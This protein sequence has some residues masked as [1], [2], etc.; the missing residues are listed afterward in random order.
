MDAGAGEVGARPGWKL[1][2]HDEFDAAAGSLPDAT[3]WVF[4]VGGSGWGNNQ[5]EFDTARPENAAHDGQGELV[6]TARKESY[7]GK[8]YTSARLKTQGK[9]ESTYGR[10]E[11]RMKIPFGQGIWPAFWMLGADIAANAWPNCGEIDIMENVGKEPALVYGTLHGP[12]YS[13][14]NGV[15]ASYMVK[16]AAR[17]AD[18]YH[19]FAIEWEKDVVR[20]YVD[21]QLYQTRKPSDLPG[22]A[23]WVYDHDFFVL[24]NLAVGGQWPGN[25]DATTTFPQALRVDYV[26]VY[27]RQ[28]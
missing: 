7:M 20:W 19:V 11:A 2:W 17:F 15:G 14:T 9:L 10:Y 18:D 26:R 22:G 13:G 12:G 24:L 28:P 23:K 21:D 5:L 3:R 4:D 1:I 16:G 6:I 25:P 27:E 8:S